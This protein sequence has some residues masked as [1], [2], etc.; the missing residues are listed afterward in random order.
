MD[1]QWGGHVRYTHLFVCLVVL[2]FAISCGSQGI[3]AKRDLAKRSEGSGGSKA[4]IKELAPRGDEGHDYISGEVL[5]RFEDGTD[6]QTIAAIQQKLNLTTIRIV[7]KP[8]LYLMKI[9]DNTS[10]KETI[11]RLM[12]LPEVAFSEPNYLRRAY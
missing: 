6:I 8:Y 9:Q 11:E 4:G 3:D 1:L 7:S 10:V 2:L 12:E 5:V